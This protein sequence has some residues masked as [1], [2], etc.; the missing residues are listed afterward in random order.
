MVKRT[1]KKTRSSASK[2]N[3]AKLIARKEFPRSYRLDAEIMAILQTTL[4]KVNGSTPKKISEA[5]LM[6]ALIWLSQE[7]S[8]K[9]IL[10]AL[11][12]V[13]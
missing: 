12:E 2:K 6:K 7:M 5:K 4:S 13:W 8:E 10:K 3:T 1:T 9:E 11:K